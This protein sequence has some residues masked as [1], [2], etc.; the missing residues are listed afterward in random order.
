MESKQDSRCNCVVNSGVREIRLIGFGIKFKI[1]TANLKIEIKRQMKHVFI[2]RNTHKL[3]TV[4][5][6]L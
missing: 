4:H 5:I 6:Q 1:N 3:L 2:I